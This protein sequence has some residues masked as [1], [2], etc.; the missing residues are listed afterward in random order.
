MAL[1]GER[2]HQRPR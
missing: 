2:N 1:T